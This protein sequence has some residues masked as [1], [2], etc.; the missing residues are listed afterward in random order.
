[1][2]RR[3]TGTHKRKT[4]GK[5]KTKKRKMLSTIRESEREKTRGHT[6]M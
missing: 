6:M 3:K 2:T 5:E 4:D 1:M